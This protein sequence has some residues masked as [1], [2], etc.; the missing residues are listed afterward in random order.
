MPADVLRHLVDLA[1]DG[2]GGVP[3]LFAAILVEDDEVDDAGRGGEPED[4]GAE[5]L[6]GIGGFLGDLAGSLFRRPELLAGP[7]PGRAE[8]LLDGR[9]ELLDP[10]L[11]FGRA[12]LRGF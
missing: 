1:A 2:L 10:L 9:L 12:L 7:F 11:N 5:V 8:L 4:E 6:A 3:D